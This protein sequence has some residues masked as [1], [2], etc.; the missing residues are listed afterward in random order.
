MLRATFHSQ[1]ILILKQLLQQ[2]LVLIQ[3]RKKKF[4]VSYV[5]IVAFHPQLKLNRIMIQRSYAHSIEQLTSLNY[6]TQ[7]RIKFLDNDLTKMLEDIAFDVSKRKCKNT[8]GQMFC[9]ESALV[10]KTLLRWFNTKY[11]Q[12]FVKMA[13]FTKIRFEKENSIN[14]KTQTCVICRLSLKVEPTNF[15]TPDDEMSY[16]D[17]VIRYEPKFLRN[18]YTYEQIKDS[19]HIADL[20]SYYKI[21]EE[22]IAMCVGLLALLNNSIEMNL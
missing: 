15:K 19:Y 1:F 17:F 21:F 5:M 13:P 9:I 12:Q 4:V 2:I 7:E 8:M 14:W 3:N 16:G 22:Y 10:K 11:K 20:E 6:F 18:I